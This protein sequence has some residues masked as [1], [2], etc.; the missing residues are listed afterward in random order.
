VSADAAPL[1]L[2]TPGPTRVPDR[3]LR[4]GAQPMI[5]HRT[6]EF[7]RALAVM[8]EGLGPLFGTR[9]PVLPV[10][11]TGRG[12]MEAAICNLFSPGDE[13]A[14]CC[15][16]KFGE[17]WA[18]LAELYGLVVHRIATDWGRSVAAGD[19]E[20][21]LDA[22][23]GIRA[24]LVAYCDTTNG[25]RN[26][27][28]RIARVV[29][30]RERLVLVDGV[31]ALGGMP[32]AFDDWGVDLAVT[33]SQK[34][35]MSSPGLAFVALSERAWATSRGARLPRSYWDFTAILEHVTRPRPETPGTPPVHTVLQVAEAV[36]LIAEEGIERVFRRHEEMAQLARRRSGE[37]GLLLQCPRLDGFASTVTA[38]AL[39]PGV[40]PKVLRGRLKELGILTA[41]G[42]GKFEPRGFRIGHMGDIRVSDVAR[43]M[44][45]LASVL[46]NVSVA[47]E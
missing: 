32:F 26:D 16:G 4:A 5:H 45:A 23:R 41:A 40:D 25:V 22:N 11:T 20:H 35:L 17:M 36:S 42:L 37:L 34:C 13:V 1:L 2:M 21:A 28:E 27:V 19:I 30:E 14:A 12:A 8:L 18:D 24:V 15:N 47:A 33:A 44:D 7:S 38:L 6:P 31:S 29:R 9:E 43:T 10:H 39:P 46:D 3:V